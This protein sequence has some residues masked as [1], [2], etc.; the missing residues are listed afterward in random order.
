MVSKRISIPPGYLAYCEKKSL[1]G[2]FYNGRNKRKVQILVAL[3]EKSGQTAS[4]LFIYAGRGATYGSFRSVLSGLVKWKY[5]SFKMVGRDRSYHVLNKGWRLV[6]SCQQNVPDEY[7]E[8]ISQ[9]RRPIVP[10]I[11]ESAQLTAQ[12]CA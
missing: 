12:Y 11:S 2:R 6:W 7:Q 9:L 1:Y 5:V 10:A 8:W 3:I 4:S